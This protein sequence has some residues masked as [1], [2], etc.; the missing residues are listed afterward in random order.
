MW[1]AHLPD[2]S[3]W[4]AP[5]RKVL[6]HSCTWIRQNSDLL[7]AIGE[8]LLAQLM[9]NQRSVCHTDLAMLRRF[10]P[11]MQAP[12][13]L[14]N[15]ATCGSRFRIAAEH[16]RF[17][18][19]PDCCAYRSSALPLVPSYGKAMFRRGDGVAERDVAQRFLV[20]WRRAT[21]KA[22]FPGEGALGQAS[23]CSCVQLPAARTVRAQDRAQRRSKRLVKI[24]EIRLR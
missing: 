20:L 10:R 17:G 1:P 24:Y 2:C 14:R 5:K 6:Q 23:S 18:P 11:D 7:G 9:P 4:L 12:R 13:T 8:L 16:W 21:T 19:S 22:A 15:S 3:A